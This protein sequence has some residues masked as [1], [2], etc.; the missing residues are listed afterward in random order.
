MKKS[1]EID[2]FMASKVL[3]HEVFHE[4][5]GEIREQLPSGQSR[6]L[7]A[8]SQDI[9][10][11]WEIVEKLGITLLPVEDGWFAM[12]GEK[13]GWSSPAEFLRYLQRADFVHSGAALGDKAP[14][15][16]C[17]AAMKALEHRPDATPDG[18]A[19]S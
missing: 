9:A 17:M 3:G 5:T 8:Y 4:E 16:I 12:V 10:A 2:I 18:T 13:R 6:P 7:R 15:T 19:L 1:R 14:M 11:A